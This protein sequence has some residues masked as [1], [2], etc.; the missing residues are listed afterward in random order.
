MYRFRPL[1]AAL[2]LAALLCGTAHSQDLTVDT[3][4]AGALID[5]ALHH[6]EVMSNLAYLT[7]VIGPRLTGSPAMRQ[8]NEWT[9]ARFW[10]YGLAAHLESWTFGGFW[11]RGPIRVRLVAPRV[12]DV[13]AASWAWAP[14]TGGVTRTGPVVRINGAVPDSFAIQRA[15]VKGAW[16]MLREPSFVWNSDGP[17]M[18][19]ADSARREQFLR[20][21]YEPFQGTD[22]ATR[23]RLQQFANDLPYLLRR[24]GALG[25]V[26]DAGK[27]QGLLN[28]SGSP[29]RILPLPQIVVAHED[30]TL[31]DRLLAASAVPRLAVSIVNEMRSDSVPQW[32]TIAELPGAERPGEV[33]I[34]GAHLD[35][36]D[37]G[38]GATD[39][40]TGAMS[41]LETARVIAQ[42]RLR[43]RRTIRFVLFTGEEQGLIGS[44]KYAQAHATEADLIQAVLVLDNGTGAVTGQALQ[45]RGD[46]EAL[47][48]RIL[49]P[50]ASLGADS[51]VSRNK[52]GTDHLSFLPYGV[53]A[54]NFNQLERGNSHTH[55]SQSDTYDKA[56]A[57]D[58][59]QASAVLAVAAYELANLPG[60]IPRGERS[61]PTPVQAVPVS[62]SLRHSR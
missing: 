38:T 14:G 28:M 54:F 29:N 6:S 5:Q 22:S 23:V 4:G 19:A 32:N 62:D 40:G 7:D 13:I 2:V 52:G 30:Y 41:V 42:S 44:R 10:D 16:V 60:M 1:A 37:L 35:S 17:P 48:R 33:V 18:G 12:H 39:N 8:A 47:W 25:I 15:R 49:A 27:E 9:L 61:T 50:V 46:L 3:T 20:T 45:G 59:M 34:V 56:L 58:L 55:H 57:A 24:A 53:P 26:V 11:T 51:V 31:F 36:W 43:P 21:F